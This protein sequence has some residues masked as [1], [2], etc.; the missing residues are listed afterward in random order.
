[1]EKKYQLYLATIAVIVI[2]IVASVGAVMFYQGQNANAP[3]P[4]PSPTPSQS[5]APTSSPSPSPTPSLPITLTDNT[6]HTLTLNAYP[7]RI[8]S[9]APANTQILFAIGAGDKVVGVTDYD[10]YPYN[11]S[12]WVAAGNMTSIGSYYDPAIEPIIA[13]NPDLIVAALG[14]ADQAVQLQNL[15]YNVLT[16][17]PADLN[18]ILDNILLVGKA[19]N[20]TADATILVSNLQQRRDAVVNGVANVTTKPKVYVEIYS[21]PYISIGRG[22]FIDG[23]IKLAGGQ[24]IFENATTEWPEVSSEAIIAQNPDKIVF[25]TSMGED[26][27]GSFE[28]LAAR[29]GWSAITAIKNNAKYLV[30]ADSLNQPGPRQVDALEALAKIIHPEIFGNYTYQP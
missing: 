18:D 19:T 2:I 30:N 17:N 25:P 9:L 12:E 7:E 14:S 15:G 23:L 24:N 3:S 8:V 26:L 4:S 11:F 20:H 1:M 29:D 5:P 16:L 28:G 10:N 22:T 6:N 21:S 27:T 13:L